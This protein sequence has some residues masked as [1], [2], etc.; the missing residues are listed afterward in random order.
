MSE[1]KISCPTCGQ[2]IV[3]DDAWSG[4]THTELKGNFTASQ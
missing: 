3:V 1:V 4:Q 2:H